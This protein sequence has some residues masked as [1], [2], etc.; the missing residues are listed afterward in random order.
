[1]FYYLIHGVA[2][3]LYDSFANIDTI[4]EILICLRNYILGVHKANRVF[5]AETLYYNITFW[6]QGHPKI[7][8][9]YLWRCY[10]D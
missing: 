4:L 8:L 1:M 7:I 6:K 3:K 9:I 5:A 2:S 10:F